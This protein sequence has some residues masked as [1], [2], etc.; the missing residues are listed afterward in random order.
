M[1]ENKGAS[2]GPKRD[3]KGRLLPGSS[4]NPGGRPKGLAAKVRAETRDGDELV[5]FH[6]A[7]LR[8]EIDTTVIANGVPTE[9]PAPLK[10]RLTAAAWLAERGFGKP[11]QSVK[12]GGD[13]SSPLTGLFS[14]LPADA[15]LDALKTRG[16]GD[17]R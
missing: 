7:V 8:G 4:G 5:E 13:E 6:L 15:L 1:P 11:E 14:Q 2:G 3:A 9:I 16:N 17:A 12:V 10:E